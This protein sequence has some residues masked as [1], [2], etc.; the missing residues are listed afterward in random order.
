M[1]ILYVR[2]VYHVLAINACVFV[3]KS[4]Y[5]SSRLRLHNN[6]TFVDQK[7]SFLVLFTM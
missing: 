4:C 7:L 6:T 5:V 3:S 2:K 1:Y